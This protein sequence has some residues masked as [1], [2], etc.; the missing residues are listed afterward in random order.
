MN[1]VII[2]KAEQLDCNDVFDWRNDPMSIK[3]SLQSAQV[4]WNQHLV[5]FNDSL[6]DPNRAMFIC[7]DPSSKSKVGI[8]RYD[9]L[10]NSCTVSINLAPDMRGKGFS[11][12]CLKS[13]IDFVRKQFP[14]IKVINASIKSSNIKSQKSFTR[15]GFVFKEKSGDT[16]LYTFADNSI[17]VT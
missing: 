2:R 6:K 9:L 13:S 5:W 11:S 17:N 12:I 10:D 4:S 1:R 14:H 16:K 3:M 7:E 15:A 8:V